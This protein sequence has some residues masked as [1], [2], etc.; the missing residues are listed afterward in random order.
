MAVL[1]SAALSWLVMMATGLMLGALT[2][3]WLGHLDSGHA[4]EYA[5]SFLLAMPVPFLLVV[6]MVFAPLALGLRAI[7]SGGT[8]PWAFGGACVLTAPLAGLLLLA[9]GAAIWGPPAT[10]GGFIKFIVPLLAI[11]SGGMAFG[12]AFGRVASANRHNNVEELS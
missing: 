3:S 12:V 11:A 6:A 10:G 4:G 5:V 7:S 1:P 8:S 2:E 9:I